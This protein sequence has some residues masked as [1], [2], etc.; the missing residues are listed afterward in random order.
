MVLPSAFLHHQQDLDV[1]V[2]KQALEVYWDG[3]ANLCV[4]RYYHSLLSHKVR[5]S[6][7]PTTLYICAS[8]C[9][10]R[11]EYNRSMTGTKVSSVW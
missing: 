6:V 5:Q 7:N 4:R 2:L 10:W 1:Y 11:T 3:M 9:L 8:S